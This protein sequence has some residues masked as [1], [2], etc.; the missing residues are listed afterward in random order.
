MKPG[1][2]HE[3]AASTTRTPAGT[4]RSTPTAAI[5]PSS[6]R[7]VAPSTGSPAI[8]TTRPPTIATDLSAI[9]P[10]CHHAQ[11]PVSRR[12][13]AVVSGLSRPGSPAGP[14]AAATTVTTVPGPRPGAP[15]ALQG[16]RARL[17]RLLRGTEFGLEHV[18]GLEERRTLVRG[19]P[20]QHPSQRR[21]GPIEPSL[22]GRPGGRGDLDDGAPPVRLV[23]RALDETGLVQGGD[24]AAHGG[25]RQ[26]KPDGER[27][28]AQRAIAQLLQRGHVPRSEGRGRP[29]RGLVLVAP[30]PSDDPREHAHQAQAQGGMPAPVRFLNH[31]ITPRLTAALYVVVRQ[32]IG[33]AKY[34]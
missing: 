28:D 11:L 15:R 16:S 14:R 5:L 10:P 20:V 21:G 12:L 9:W 7:I 33:R 1:S 4:A 34:F 29:R 32:M 26:A 2:T 8:G 13:C 3:P 25:Q 24:D 18:H 31:P 19:Q 27:P 6:T 23:S 30:H 22:H 17:R